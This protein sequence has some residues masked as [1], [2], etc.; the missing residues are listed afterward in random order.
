MSDDAYTQAYGSCERCGRPLP[1]GYAPAH[2]IPRSAVG[3]TSDRSW[4]LALLCVDGDNC[5]GWFDAH[6]YE[7]SKEEWLK[8]RI[9]AEP[10][11]KK[12]FD[13]IAAKRE[14]QDEDSAGRD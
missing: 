7:A 4:N 3:E 10:R 13:K 8:K 1:P 6:R 14:W 12:Y 2:I 9:D 5:H 11:L